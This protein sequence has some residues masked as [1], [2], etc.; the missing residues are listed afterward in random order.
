MEPCAGNNNCA[1]RE[2][3]LCEHRFVRPAV[4]RYCNNRKEFFKLSDLGIVLHFLDQLTQ[5]SLPSQLISDFKV[6]I[7]TKDRKF[8][9]AAQS[10]WGS[11]RHNRPGIIMD[12]N[13]GSIV[14]HSSGIEFR[15]IEVKCKAYGSDAK[16]DR[17]CAIDLVNKLL[18]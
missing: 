2:H 5:T 9:E 16:T 10:E 13:P 6:L 1:N 7:L 18:S 11:A 3:V 4:V 8:V 15:V 12:F 17:K 14:E